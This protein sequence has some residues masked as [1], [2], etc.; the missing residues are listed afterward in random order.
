MDRKKKLIT[1]HHLQKTSNK[2]LTNRRRQLADPIDVQSD[3][4]NLSWLRKALQRWHWCLR[5]RQEKKRIEGE[6]MY[7]ECNFHFCSA[8]LV[9][10]FHT[11]IPRSSCNFLVRVKPCNH[12]IHNL[13]LSS[14]HNWGPCQCSINWSSFIYTSR[15]PT[16]YSS[17]FHS[18]P[19]RSFCK[20]FASCVSLFNIVSWLAGWIWLIRDRSWLS[21]VS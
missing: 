14:S 21:N 2:T 10:C 8:F 18:S 11:P 5:V 17:T 19:R 3:I 12:S 1:I 15:F 13:T 7:R 9:D 4:F 6:N 16:F 20:I